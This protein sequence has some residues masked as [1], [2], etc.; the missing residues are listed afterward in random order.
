M[1]IIIAFF[2]RTVV[3]V[4]PVLPAGT[5]DPAVRGAAAVAAHHRQDSHR[6]VSGRRQ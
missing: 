6:E 3:R 1:A 2:F 4:E 5:D